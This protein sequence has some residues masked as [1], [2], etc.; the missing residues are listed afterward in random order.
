[1]SKCAK[2]NQH[3]YYST[4]FQHTQTQR[5]SSTLL[6]TA[7]PPSI[8][9]KLHPS[10]PLSL[11]TITSNESYGWHFQYLTI[12]GLSLATMTF[13]TGLLA[14]ITLSPQLF[15]IKNLLSGCSAPLQV[16]ISTLYWGLSAIDRH[17]VVPP[18]LELPV[19]PG[20]HLLRG[21]VVSS[22]LANDHQISAST[23]S[24]PSS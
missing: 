17:L 11:L 13:I 22:R 15:L 6:Y 4:V 23:P 20:E 9:T 14:D 5:K 7:K 21:V 3:A 24:P 16:L 1:M 19:L 18:D 12:I 8:P 10:L 2:Q